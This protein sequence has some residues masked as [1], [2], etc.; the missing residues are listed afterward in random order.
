MNERLKGKSALIVGASRGLGRACAQVLAEQGAQLTLVARDGNAL[1]QLIEELPQACEPHRSIP[2][3]L[4]SEDAVKELIGFLDGPRGVPSIVVHNIG[5]SGGVKDPFAP[6]AEWHRIWRL[7]LGIPVAINAWLLPKL[8]EQRFGRVVHV[9]SASATTFRGYPAYVAAK[10]ALVGYVKSV[11]RECA[12]KG[13]V[14][15]C[16]APG[17]MRESGRFLSELETAGGAGWEKYCDDHLAIRRLADCIEV[18]HV[19][20]FL[21]GSE[22][23]YC[24]G[25]IF[26]ADG[27]SM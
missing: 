7:N 6:E 3:D 16:V 1:S 9:G 23:S 18:A 2:I 12:A 13:V 10:S 22:A 25:S 19:V 4:S 26:G 8:V 15:S 14:V 5:G 17:A 24:G 21:C 20:A 11:G 27:G